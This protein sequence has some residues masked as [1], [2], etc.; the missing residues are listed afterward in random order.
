[1]QLQAM[2]NQSNRGVKDMQR[3]QIWVSPHPAGWAIR[4]AG[5]SRASS[6]CDTKQEAVIRARG[7]AQREEAELI[8]QRKDGT[9]QQSDSHGHDPCPPKDAR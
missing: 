6:V 9:I 1:M 4:R 3:N 8:V 5:A 2:K 7:K